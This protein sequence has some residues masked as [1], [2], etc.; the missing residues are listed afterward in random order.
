MKA[1]FYL[2]ICA[3][4]QMESGPLRESLAGSTSR[5]TCKISAK[6]TFLLTSTDGITS[7]QVNPREVA[8]CPE[9]LKRGA[10]RAARLAG[11]DILGAVVGAP[12][13]VFNTWKSL[14]ELGI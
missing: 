6:V 14:H 5:H 11:D 10:E 8:K 3:F 4:L 2:S 12:N 1:S 7:W 9:L 13:P